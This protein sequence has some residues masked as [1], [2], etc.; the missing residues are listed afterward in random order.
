MAG[1]LAHVR[2]EIAQTFKRIPLEC[3]PLEQH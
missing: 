3:H 2:R 1:L